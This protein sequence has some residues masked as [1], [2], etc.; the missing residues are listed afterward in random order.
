MKFLKIILTITLISS[1]AFTAMHKYYVSITK[2]EYVKEKKSVQIITRIFIDDFEKLLRERY[3][4]SI[5]LASNQDETQIDQYIEKY[6]LSRL[7]ISIN[8]K[9]ASVQFIG[10]E[11]DEDVVQCYLE[12]E[13]I[14]A[15]KTF[16]IENKILF[17]VFSDQKNIVR[18]YINNKH[19]SFILIP[20]RIKGMLNF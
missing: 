20:E 15:V 14:T 17:D 5:V 16:E 1:L 7:K 12:I 3:D 18:T 4:E 8:G 10:K 19:K 6:V 2:I 9:L 13:N 11:Y